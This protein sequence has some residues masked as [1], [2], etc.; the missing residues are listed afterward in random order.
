MNNIKATLKVEIIEG[1]TLFD[2]ILKL[3]AFISKSGQL[4][5]FEL[6]LLPREGW[7]TLFT[8]K[9]IAKN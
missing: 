9:I 5:F 4:V 8:S 1:M 6:M 3:I 2:Y 7:A